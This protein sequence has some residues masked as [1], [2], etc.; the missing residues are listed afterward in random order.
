M[1]K[2]IYIF[3]VILLS[4]TAIPVMA[5]PVTTFK[6]LINDLLITTILKPL[7]PLLI[8]L[9]IVVFFYGIIVFV[10]SEGGDKKQDGKQYM[11]W[12]VIGIFVMVSVWGLVDLLKDT[13]GL[14][15]T[16][17]NI[18]ITLPAGSTAGTQAEVNSEPVG[19][20]D[21]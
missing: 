3:S 19:G 17:P 4:A 5:A 11:F 7:I 14:D 1:K 15:Q 12:G 8:G 6:Q 16:V 9:A 10:L 13:F 2:I 18:Q 20:F 21:Y